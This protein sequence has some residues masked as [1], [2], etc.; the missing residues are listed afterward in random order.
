[1]DELFPKVQFQAAVE[2]ENGLVPFGKYKGQPVQALL[3]DH[4]YLQWLLAQAWFMQRYEQLYTLVLNRGVMPDETPEHNALQL[5][6]LDDGLCLQA[7]RA[8]RARGDAQPAS[9]AVLYDVPQAIFE[10]QGIDVSLTYRIAVWVDRSSMRHIHTHE[11]TF[12]TWIKGMDRVTLEL[13]PSLGDD[14]P[15]VLRKMLGG[16]G[17]MLVYE[18]WQSQ[19]P[20]AQVKQ[21]F[22]RSNRLLISLEELAGYPA[23]PL[24]VPTEP[25]EN[26]SK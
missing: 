17:M 18:R 22:A 23:E 26:C 15:A 6:F 3:D 10:Q 8:W 2:P 7:C 24:P 19:M 12:W 5:R 11:E 13:K 4:G 1:M 20:V 9:H 25:P 16:S 14:Y 21:L